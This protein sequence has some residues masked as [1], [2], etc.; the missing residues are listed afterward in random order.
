MLQID[1]SPNNESFDS[2]IKSLNN[3]GI[4]AAAPMIGALTINSQSKANRDLFL[5]DEAEYFSNVARRH[6]GSWT[7]RSN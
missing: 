3:E 6:P 4:I 7:A 5:R 2:E 1:N